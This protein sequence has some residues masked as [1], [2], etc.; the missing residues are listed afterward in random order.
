MIPFAILSPLHLFPLLA[1]MSYALLWNKFMNPDTA[2]SL[3][4]PTDEG[5]DEEPSILSDPCLS[6]GLDMETFLGDNDTNE[7]RSW[8]HGVRAETSDESECDDIYGSGEDDDDDI[9]D[10]TTSN[11]LETFAKRNDAEDTQQSTTSE[12][13]A[14]IVEDQ[15]S[16]K[17]SQFMPTH[18]ISTVVR[19]GQQCAYIL[20]SKSGALAV[21]YGSTKLFRCIKNS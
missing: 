8:I 3:S 17:D 2:G 19:R 15:R 7:Q 16:S 12:F 9:G 20:L 10:C 13:A 5:A 18:V 14:A 1:S 4:E 11:A 6:Y 21:K